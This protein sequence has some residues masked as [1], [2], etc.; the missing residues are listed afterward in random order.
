MLN[1]IRILVKIKRAEK[2]WVQLRWVGWHL[3]IYSFIRISI[4]LFISLIKYFVVRWFICSF[5]NL[6]KHL[7]IYWLFIIIVTFDQHFW[8]S[9]YPSDHILLHFSL[10]WFPV[11]YPTSLYFHPLSSPSIFRSFVCVFI[12]ENDN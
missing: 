5:A 12:I 3:I 11:S 10:D 7:F 1:K 2:H 8:S 9:S 4:S 6:C